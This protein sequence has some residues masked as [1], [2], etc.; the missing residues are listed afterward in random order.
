MGSF[1]AAARR[2]R[3]SP[4]SATRA[5]AYLESELGVRLLNRTTRSVRLTEEGARFLAACRQVLADLRAAEDS[6]KGTLPEPQGSLVVSAPVV[7]GRIHVVPIVTAVLLRNP[8]LSVR[9]ALIDRTTELV[10]EGIDV[11]VRIGELPDS[12][13][14]AVQ[15]GTIQ[16]VIVASPGYLQRHGAPAAPTDLQRHELIMFTA[17]STC[18]EWL[19]GRGGKRGV[20]VRPRMSVNTADAAISAAEAGFG[21]ARVLSYQVTAAVGAGRLVRILD[22]EAPPSVPVS[23]IF[24]TGRD[25]SPNVRTFIDQSKEYFRSHPL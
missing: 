15:I 12:S 20:R 9:L 8:R 2:L 13:V 14:H 24:Q 4:Q 1:G 23:L 21:I 11:A 19:F 5:V 18:D 6:L 10:E 17:A 25:R 16:Y 7:F 3:V 22:S